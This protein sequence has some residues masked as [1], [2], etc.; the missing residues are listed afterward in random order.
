VADAEASEVLEREAGWRP[1]RRLVA[2]VAALVLGIGLVTW[3]V[4]HTVRD[5]E[6]RA[7]AA[8]AAD[9]GTAVTEAY[10]PVL[11]MTQ[12]VRPVLDSGPSGRLR[13]N[14]YSM[15]S[16]TAAGV[17]TRLGPARNTC[18][19]LDVLWT[20]PAIRARRDACVRALDER[21]AFLR[22]VRRDGHEAFRRWPAAVTGC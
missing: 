18:R 16:R 8:C 20:H 13:R 14:M 21:A 22:A 6:Q 9:A 2:A 19:D 17:D 11:A 3:A 12:Y 10:A 7:V 15:V 4:D 5:R 1:S